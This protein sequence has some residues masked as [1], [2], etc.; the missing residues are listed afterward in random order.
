MRPRRR[1][2]AALLLLLPAANAIADFHIDWQAINGGGGVSTAPG[3]TLAGTI[4]Q[5]SPGYSDG[6]A[7]QLTAGFWVAAPLVSDRIFIDGFQGA[8]P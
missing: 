2:G 6:G 4:G 3:I 5:P 8:T 1:A 7:Y